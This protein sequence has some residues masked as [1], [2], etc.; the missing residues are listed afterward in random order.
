MSYR[1]REKGTGTFCA[2]HAEGRSGKRCLSPFPRLFLVSVVR[3]TRLQTVG[4]D[5][6]EMLTC[7]G[8]ESYAATVAGI[9]HRRVGQGRASFWWGCA[10]RSIVVQPFV[11]Q[12]AEL[13]RPKPHQHL[14]LL[15]PP[16]IWRAG[17]GDR[18]LL[19][20]AP[21]GPFR[22]KVP[23]PFSRA[24]SQRYFFNAASSALASWR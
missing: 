7:A 17:K 15:D 12:Q 21:E 11:A 1:G 13:P 8:G 24:P 9:F 3:G 18:H 20:E 22:Q 19:C 2:K 10:N 16:Y 4:D 23:V 5:F 6:A 14:G